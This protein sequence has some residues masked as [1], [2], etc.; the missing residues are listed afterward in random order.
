[1]SVERRTL[2]KSTAAGAAVGGPFAGPGGDAG[3]GRTPPDPGALV[4]LPDERDGVVRLHLPRGSSTGPS[5][6]PRH[7]SR[8]PTAPLC[9]AGTT[10]WA[11]STGHAGA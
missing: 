4:P 5:T 9:P 6:T 1:M 3:R 11:R 10:A 7:R 2:L 8:S